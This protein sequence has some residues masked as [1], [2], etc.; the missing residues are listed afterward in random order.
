MRGSKCL[1]QLDMLHWCRNFMKYHTHVQGKVVFNT[2]KINSSVE[3][4]LY[5]MNDIA[6]SIVDSTDT[7]HCPIS[8]SIDS[9]SNS[10]EVLNDINSNPEPMLSTTMSSTASLQ[11]SRHHHDDSD[12]EAEIELPPLDKIIPKDVLKKLKPKEKKRQDVLNGEY[13]SYS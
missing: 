11:L 9:P 4:F 3:G 6:V 8:R 1:V 12:F 10:N 7:L 5:T 2:R 13:S